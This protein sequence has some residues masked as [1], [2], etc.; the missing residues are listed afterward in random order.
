MTEPEFTPMP[1]VVP[2]E[3]PDPLSA[4]SQDAAR[5]WNDALWSHCPLPYQGRP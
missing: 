4:A 1:A 5:Q 2:D 3:P